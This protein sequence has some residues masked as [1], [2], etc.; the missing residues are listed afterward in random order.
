ML[1]QLN[2]FAA[3][4]NGAPLM[5]FEMKNKVIWYNETVFAAI[6]DEQIL[7]Q[8]VY[9]AFNSFT[10]CSIIEKWLN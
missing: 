9:D 4:S 2:R 10:R 6:T 8:K 5:G 3:H 1:V 7:N